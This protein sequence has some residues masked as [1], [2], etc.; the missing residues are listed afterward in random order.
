MLVFDRLPERRKYLVPF[1]HTL[2]TDRGSPES[3]TSRPLYRLATR[4]PPKLRAQP[5]VLLHDHPL[6]TGPVAPSASGLTEA[7]ATENSD[8]FRSK[9]QGSSPLVASAS[10]ELVEEPQVYP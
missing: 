9:G 7:V 1:G 8:P 2:Q 10:D 5:H 4:C 6:Q 3:S